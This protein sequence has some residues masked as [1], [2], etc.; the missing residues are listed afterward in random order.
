MDSQLERL[1]RLETQSSEKQ[2]QF[3]K[4]LED[5]KNHDTMLEQHFQ[6]MLEKHTR[7]EMRVMTEILAKLNAI[8][9]Q[10]AKYKSMLGGVVMTVSAVWFVVSQLISWFHIDLIQII[11]TALKR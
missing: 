3:G 10:T 9:S 6:D 4:A 5:L 8:E 11:L 7:E 2:E 1:V